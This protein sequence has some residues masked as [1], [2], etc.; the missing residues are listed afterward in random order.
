MAEGEENQ[1]E[2]ATRRRINGKKKS[3]NAYENFAPFTEKLFH[4]NHLQRMTYLCAIRYTNQHIKTFLE[5]VNSKRCEFAENNLAFFFKACFP[6]IV[7]F[8]GFPN[9]LSFRFQLIVVCE[10]LKQ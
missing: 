2:H 1:I 6:F 7:T 9:Y 3:E 8:E 10:C 4:I 5:C